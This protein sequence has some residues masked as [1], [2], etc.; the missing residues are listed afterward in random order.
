MQ[1]VYFSLDFSSGTV[2][3][4]DFYH[5]GLAAPIYTHFTSPIRGFVRF[6]GYGLRSDGRTML[7][8]RHIILES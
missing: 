1:A 2:A 7:D 6:A 3:Q 8:Y 5:Y 4:V